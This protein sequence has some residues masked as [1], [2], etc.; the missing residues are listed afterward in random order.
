MTATLFSL[1]N[2]VKLNVFVVLE[3]GF[4]PRNE[5]FENILKN[6]KNNC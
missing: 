4:I 2:D 3:V 5:V 6:I 1:E